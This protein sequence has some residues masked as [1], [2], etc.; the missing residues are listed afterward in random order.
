MYSKQPIELTFVRQWWLL[1]NKLWLYWRFSSKTSLWGGQIPNAQK[2]RECMI[3]LLLRLDNA[4]RGI[5]WSLHF[6]LKF[7]KISNND[8]DLNL[9]A[10]PDI[11]LLAKCIKHYKGASRAAQGSAPSIKSHNV[12]CDQD[13]RHYWG[14]HFISSCPKPLFWRCR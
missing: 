9:T 2:L 4:M 7:H 10:P 5:S 1:K 3:K 8:T 11:Q 6:W 12:R 14:I 13:R